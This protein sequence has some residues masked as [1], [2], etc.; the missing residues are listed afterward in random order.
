M[1]FAEALLNIQIQAV[2]HYVRIRKRLRPPMPDRTKYIDDL[3]EQLTVHTYKGK[4]A[5]K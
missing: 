2:R 4:V 3:V 1:S 5:A